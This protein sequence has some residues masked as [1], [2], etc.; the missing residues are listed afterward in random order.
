[1]L[2]HELSPA[3]VKRALAIYLEHAWPRSWVSKTRP[4]LEGIERAASNKELLEAF[5]RP[6]QDEDG[7]SCARFTLRLGNERYPFMKF[8]VQE[9]L[10]GREVFFSVDSHDNLDVREDNPDYDAWLELKHHNREL[11]QRIEDAWAQAGLPT[12]RD[13][14][15]IAREL[16]KIECEAH[17]RARILVVDDEQD[18]CRG[19]GTLLE[20][21]GYEVELAYDG[22]QVLERIARDPLP[23]LIVLDYSMPEYNGEEVL[24]ALRAQARTQ[25][26]PVLLA[27]ASSIH[28][29]D[30]PQATAFLHKPYPREVLF[31]LI[32]RMLQNGRE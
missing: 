25:R 28:R 23:D 4:N 3:L 10:V 20:A 29:E 30:L 11:K 7:P 2:L 17:K 31:P 24:S 27:T 1:M 21:R 12:H 6:R 9:Y 13:L 8:V 16:A 18:V 26:L 5:D 22:R 32:T 15:R 14:L 19:L